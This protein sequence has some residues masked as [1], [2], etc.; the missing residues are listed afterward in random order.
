MRIVRVSRPDY[1]LFYFPG[2]GITVRLYR[3]RVTVRTSG[4]FRRLGWFRFGNERI[5]SLGWVAFTATD[6]EVPA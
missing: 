2:Y 5:L 4:R 1:G 6:R 3:Y